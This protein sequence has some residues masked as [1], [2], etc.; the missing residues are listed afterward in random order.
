MTF[1]DELKKQIVEEPGRS[2]CCRRA[3]LNGIVLAK[4]RI[5]NGSIILSLGNSDAVAY[6]EELIHEFFGQT[7]EVFASSDGGHRRLLSFR[8]PSMEKYLK[9][10]TLD[11]HR[12]YTRKCTGCDTAFMSG[13][14]AGENAA[15]L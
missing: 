10:L 6:T 15:T 13:I 4:G 11:D 1:L 7:A 3:M 8:S 12:F 2:S 14:L 5:S 9:G